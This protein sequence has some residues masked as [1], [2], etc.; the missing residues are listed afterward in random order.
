VEDDLIVV[1]KWEN[2]IQIINLNLLNYFCSVS[3]EK[4]GGSQSISEYLFKSIDQ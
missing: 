4:E 1:N 2:P 3:E